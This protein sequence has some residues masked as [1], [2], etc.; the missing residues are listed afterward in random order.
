M[1]LYELLE[2]EDS[3]EVGECVG[4]LYADKEGV[5]ILVDNPELRE[6][7]FSLLDQPLTRRL[8]AP[9]TLGTAEVAVRPGEEGYEDALVERLRKKDFRLHL[10]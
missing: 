4:E 6:R 10:E 8:A 3:L 1:L 7:L 2:T 5:E 9:H